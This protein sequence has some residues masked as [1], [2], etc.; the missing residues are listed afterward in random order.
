MDNRYAHPV[1]VLLPK[2]DGRSGEV[3]AIR[4]QAYRDIT[5]ELGFIKKG[6]SGF[7]PTS[8]INKVIAGGCSCKG[9]P[10]WFRII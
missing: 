2:D 3:Q 4:V 7:V 5:T 10:N 9:S 6:E 8:W 1:L